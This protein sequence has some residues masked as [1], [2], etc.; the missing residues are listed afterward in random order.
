MLH[1]EAPAE[2][3]CHGPPRSDAASSLSILGPAGAVQCSEEQDVWFNSENTAGYSPH[4]RTINFS[5]HHQGE[6]G[7]LPDFF[8]FGSV[9]AEPRSTLLDAES[10]H[11]S[12]GSPAGSG[13][14]Q[15]HRVLANG[16]SGIDNTC[17]P[18]KYS[19]SLPYSVVDDLSVIESLTSLI[20][21]C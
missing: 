1:P 19:I 4:S 12:S 10:I 18:S 3:L 5:P 6:E 2:A 9:L 17:T 21:P 14:V 8:D 15:T 13:L 7:P 20:L 11:E 16:L